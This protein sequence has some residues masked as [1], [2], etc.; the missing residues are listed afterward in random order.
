MKTKN[1]KE[2][3]RNSKQHYKDVYAVDYI[4]TSTDSLDHLYQS[5][6]SFANKFGGY[7]SIITTNNEEQVQDL[8]KQ[9]KQICSNMEPIITP[10]ISTITIDLQT[11]INVT[12]DPIKPSLRPCYYKELGK[13]NSSF[14]RQRKEN[15]HMSEFEIY[16]YD[17]FNQ[18]IHEEVKP[19]ELFPVP[20]IDLKKQDEFIK[21][22]IQK[23]PTLKN[24][25][26]SM[27]KEVL[28]LEIDQQPT[29]LGYLLFSTCP[30]FT[31][32]ARYIQGIRP[33]DP[34]LFHQIIKGDLLTMLDEAVNF[35]EEHMNKTKCFNP[36][37]CMQCDVPQYPLNAVK[38]AVLN[39]LVHRDYSKYTK[40]KPIQI[41][42]YPDRLEIINPGSVFGKITFEDLYYSDKE[43]RNKFLFNAL[44]TYGLTDK[45]VPGYDLICQELDNLQLRG[46]AFI[47]EREQFRV[48][49]CGERY[50]GDFIT[51]LH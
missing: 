46:P 51:N 11:Y 14:I 30:Q 9:V 21:L 44:R 5:I 34:V 49:L 29:L 33:S 1:L 13:L 42:M 25:P 18:Q 50:N 38:E 48:V 39:A 7:I 41:T 47:S 12:I 32:E 6:S 31:I 2:L 28:H 24:I 26:K 4:Y 45:S 3:L 15:Q 35:V 40:D 36:I 43:I 20:N 23:D 8:I 17:A 16:Q 19:V 37:T 27:L 22:S 10:K